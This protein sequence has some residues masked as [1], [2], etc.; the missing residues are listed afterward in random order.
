[1][2]ELYAPL[3]QAIREGRGRWVPYRAE[4]DPRPPLD[5]IETALHDWNAVWEDRSREADWDTSA[6]H[7]VWVE[8]GRDLARQL[9]ERHPDWQVLYSVGGV[10]EFMRPP[11]ESLTTTDDHP[12]DDDPT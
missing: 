4:D 5:D 10:W 9:Q 8:R 1:M 11:W 7:S 2:D 6:D 12:N 3:Q